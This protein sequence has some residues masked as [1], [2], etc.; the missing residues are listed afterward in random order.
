METEA[1]KKRPNRNLLLGAALVLTGFICVFYFL[2]PRSETPEGLMAQYYE[3]PAFELS[4]DNEK[5]RLIKTSYDAGGYKKAIVLLKQEGDDPTMYYY[6]GVCNM[7]LTNADKAIPIFKKLQAN[8][9]Y[10]NQVT[11]LLALTY[12]QSRNKEAA[13]LELDKLVNAEGVSAERKGD[14]VELLGKL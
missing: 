10:S 11:W 8:P 4:Q 5:Q 9:R 12:L 7:E 6:Q 3:K 14:V 13:K 2:V 1:P